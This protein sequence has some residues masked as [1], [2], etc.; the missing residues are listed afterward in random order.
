MDH[1]LRSASRLRTIALNR[2]SVEVD[3]PAGL[4]FEVVASAGKKIRDIEGGTVVEFESV[5]RD[6]VVRT[7]EEVLLDPPRQIRYRW[8]EG[9]LE[10]VEERIGFAERGDGM[11]SMTYSGEIGT[12]GGIG[13]WSRLLMLVRPGFNRLVLEH[14]EQGKQVAEKRAQRSHVYRSR[15]GGSG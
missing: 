4:V 11:T 2:Q 1:P 12:S 6:R 3:A 14:L 5:W 13:A 9:P 8:L 15:T 10:H 7:V